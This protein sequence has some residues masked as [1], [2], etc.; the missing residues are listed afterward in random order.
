MRRIHLILGSLLA[1]LCAHGW[2][3]DATAQTPPT[4]LV[5]LGDSLSSGLLIP[6][7]RAFP[8][9]LQDA[10]RAQGFD[11]SVANAAISG[12]TT[13][14]GLARVDRDVPDGTSG[15]IL[16][17][18]ANDMLR[19]YPAREMRANLEQ[20]VRRLHA[21]GIPVMLAG[22]RLSPKSG[23]DLVGYEAAYRSVA[24]R[25]GL[26][27]YPDFYVG[28]TADPRYTIFDRTHPSSLGVQVI[29]AGIL[30]SVV[31]FVRTIEA[32]RAAP[33]SRARLSAR[34]RP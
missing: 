19:R 11:V 17:L 13:S 34:P 18:G 25:Y 1:T 5:V 31:R 14:Q 3:R 33:A 4:R 27:Y 15:V 10:L 2:S 24:R 12:N 26:V 16:E 21:R 8:T 9:A 6:P 20:I 29:V 30:P 7:W 22:L 28:L 23:A 32:P